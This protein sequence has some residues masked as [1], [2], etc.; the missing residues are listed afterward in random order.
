MQLINKL[1]EGF[2]HLLL[3]FNGEVLM[4]TILYIVAAIAIAF[5]IGMILLYISR[6]PTK[7]SQR[8]LQTVSTLDKGEEQTT[9]NKILGGISKKVVLGFVELGDSTKYRLQTA[10]SYFH[11]T[12]TP[13]EHFSDALTA[14]IC[15]ALLACVLM[16]FN[17]WF[18]LFGIILGFVIFRNEL[19]APVKRFKKVKENI[20][21]DSAIFCKFIADALKENN[22]NV[23]D[24]LTSCK[25]SV[26]T[27]FKLELEHTLTDM[28]TGNQEQALIEMGKR[29]NLSSITQIVVGLL[30]VLRGDNQTVY[31]DMLYE[32]FYKEELARIKKKNSLKVGTVSKI[33]MLLILPVVGM[34]LTGVVL[35]LLEQ[36][37]SSG[38][39]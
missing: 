14:G 4:R 21:Y 18:A 15:T 25:E 30:G 5:G 22:R 37:K 3:I 32:K 16:I 34:I 39:L 36:F 1:K 20:D 6:F 28:K 17:P 35:V 24:I 23:I 8:I 19:N 31:F 13:E 38:I 27:D 33:T 2:E 7:K 9:I 29:L 11:Y 12:V 26:S 10:L